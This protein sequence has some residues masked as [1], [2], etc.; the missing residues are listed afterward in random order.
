MNFIFKSQE[1]FRID[2]II[3]LNDVS[4]RETQRVN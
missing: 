3:F 2:N 1:A 4:N